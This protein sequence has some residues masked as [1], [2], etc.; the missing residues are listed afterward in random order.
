LVDALRTAHRPVC[1]EGVELVRRR[2]AVRRCHPRGTIDLLQR[3]DPTS[4]TL[5]P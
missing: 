2:A 4:L 3:V 5:A 1:D